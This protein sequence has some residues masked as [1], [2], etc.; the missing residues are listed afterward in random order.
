MDLPA[1]RTSRS[2]LIGHAPDRFDD[3]LRNGW[4]AD[5]LRIARIYGPVLARRWIGA[6]SAMTL[7]VEVWPLLDAAGAGTEHVVE[8]SFKTTNRT[9]ASAAHDSLIADLQRRGWLLAQDS[10]KTQLIMD[11]Y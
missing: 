5:A 4:G 7:Y 10:L 3:W 8:A 2:M 9:T 11:R 6:W 1:T